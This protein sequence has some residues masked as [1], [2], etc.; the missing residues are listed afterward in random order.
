MLVGTYTVA[1]N[2]NLRGD[3]LD[4]F[5]DMPCRDLLPLSGSTKGVLVGD[6]AP[7]RYIRI[8]NSVAATGM[9]SP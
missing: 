8:H 1:M 5:T 9:L 7:P 3:S 4:V 6:P 2:T